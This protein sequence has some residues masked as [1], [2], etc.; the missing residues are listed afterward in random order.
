MSKADQDRY[1]KACHAMQS[2]VA[3]EM[4]LPET[5]DAQSPKHL[6]VGVNSAMVET[7]TLVGLLV[8]KGIITM[9][10]WDKA[11]ADN[12]ELEVVRYEQRLHAALGKKVVLL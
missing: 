4:N 12:M 7:S 2:G 1:I 3:M 6:R 9:D 10:E 8:E 5:R 11:L